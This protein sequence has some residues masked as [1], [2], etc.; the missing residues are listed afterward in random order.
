M[1]IGLTILPSRSPSFIQACF[2][3]ASQSARVRVTMASSPASA[4]SQGW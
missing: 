3:G 2:A 1:T 4:I